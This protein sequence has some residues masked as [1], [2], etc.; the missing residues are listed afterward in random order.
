M[1]TQNRTNRLRGLRLF[2]WSVRWVNEWRTDLLS[3]VNPGSQ[4][5]HGQRVFRS[6]RRKVL[7]CSS[8]GRGRVRTSVQLQGRGFGDLREA[9]QGPGSHWHKAQ[10]IWPV[11][12]ADRALQ[13]A[14]PQGKAVFTETTFYFL[15]TRHPL[16]WR[17]WP[18]YAK[19]L[20]R[21]F[22]LV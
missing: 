5:L 8:A 12:M 21:Q 7:Y 10:P 14:N 18:E 17:K 4:W 1:M 22:L 13:W 19:H 15:F 20:C 9:V 11:S 3:F 6:W 16:K 2:F